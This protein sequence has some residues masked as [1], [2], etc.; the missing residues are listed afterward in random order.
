[1]EMVESMISTVVDSV[2]GNTNVDWNDHVID[3]ST[4]WNRYR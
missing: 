3:F 4:P 2:N 1:M